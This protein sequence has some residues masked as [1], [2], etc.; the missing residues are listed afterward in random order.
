MIKVSKSKK[1]LVL[2]AKA[3]QSTS[4]K[5]RLQELQVGDIVTGTVAN[6]VDFGAFVNLGGVDGLIH[7]SRLSWDH[8]NNPREIL[9]PGEEVKVV[10]NEVDIEN[11]RVS[12]DR[13][14]LL[15]N[16]WEQFEQQH[17]SGDILEGTIDG[18]VD[19]GAFVKLSDHINGLVHASELY[20]GI[21]H[22][23]K[24]VLHPGDTVLVRIIDIDK[25]DRRVSLSLRRVPPEDIAHW[26]IGDEDDT[27]AMVDVGAEP[28][29]V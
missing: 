20:D 17:E 18:V 2:S 13:R 21:S 11:E 16:P 8:V 27:T 9:Q 26:I 4:R 3:A 22:S 12:L 1:R 28:E 19:F 7:K 14:A 5:E 24:E 10:I 6:V 15:P 29:L 23:P 25:E